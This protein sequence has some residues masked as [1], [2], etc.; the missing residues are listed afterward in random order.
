MRLRGEFRNP[1]NLK[2]GNPALLSEAKDLARLKL[3]RPD[4]SL[5][6]KM[7]YPCGSR[8]PASAYAGDGTAKAERS[9]PHT[10]PT[11]CF[12]LSSTA[13]IPKNPWI[14]PG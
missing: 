7:T 14:M 13:D 12:A 4:S 11:A 1:V 5:S 2:L 9:A 10:S 6:L 8:A 3:D